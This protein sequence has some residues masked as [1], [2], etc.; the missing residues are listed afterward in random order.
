MSKNFVFI[1]MVLLLCEVMQAKWILNN[2]QQPFGKNIRVNNGS[3]RLLEYRRPIYIYEGSVGFSGSD[4]HG[5]DYHSQSRLQRNGN[6][7]GFIGNN[8]RVLS[9]VVKHRNHRKY[10]KASTQMKA[11]Y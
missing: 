7:A 6:M 10:I 4:Q 2:H 8:D 5:R 1:L 11:N 3:E 9:E